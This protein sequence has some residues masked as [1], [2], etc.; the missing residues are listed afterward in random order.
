M[1]FERGPV[2]SLVALRKAILRPNED[3]IS[4]CVYPGD[5]EREAVHVRGL[6]GVDAVAIGSIVP[7]QRTFGDCTAA[8]RLRGLGVA[9]P[10][11]RQGY[12]EEMLE[13]LLSIARDHGQI[14]LWGSGRAELEIWYTSIGAEAVSDVFEI[15]GTGP[16]L[17]FLI[18]DY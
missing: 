12:G 11:Q 1:T 17:N 8:W 16:H 18:R 15:D 10:F 13:F 2:G 6:V 14:P 9:P 5:L 3:D 4:W 7:D